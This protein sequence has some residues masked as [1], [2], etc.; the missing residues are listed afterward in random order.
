MKLF[1]QFG[2]TFIIF[3]TNYCPGV[4]VPPGVTTLPNS[5]RRRSDCGGEWTIGVWCRY[6][7]SSASCGW[8]II[9]VGGESEQKYMVVLF[10]TTSAPR[11][12]WTWS[13]KDPE[14][15]RCP[16]NIATSANST[17]PARDPFSLAIG[18]TLPGMFFNFY[19]IGN[20]VFSCSS[21]GVAPDL[22]Y[23]SI[24][25]LTDSDSDQPSKWITLPCHYSCFFNRVQSTPKYISLL[26]TVISSYWYWCPNSNSL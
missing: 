10:V 19:Q 14:E 1:W 12:R 25:L 7:R 8:L 16:A 15:N 21:A 4:W 6:S 26:E 22:S 3:S 2:L 9:G 23:N 13:H 5:K 11:L 20:S 17:N 18:R 24:N